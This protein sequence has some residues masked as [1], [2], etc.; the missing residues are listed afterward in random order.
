MFTDKVKL[1]FAEHRVKFNDDLMD[2]IM[3]AVI[4]ELKLNDDANGTDYASRL[5]I[6]LPAG[7]LLGHLNEPTPLTDEER[8]FFAGVMKPDLR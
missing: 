8:R 7:N 2:D 6:K 1:L 5:G 4:E 3:A